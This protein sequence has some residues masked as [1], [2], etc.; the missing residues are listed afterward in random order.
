MTPSTT[1]STPDRRARSCRRRRG[2]RRNLEVDRRWRHLDAA[3]RQRE[4]QNRAIRRSRSIKNDPTGKTIYVADGRGSARHLVDDGGRRLA[5][6]GA[7][8]GGR[9][10]VDRRRRDV[11]AAR[12]AAN[13][14]AGARRP[15]SELRPPARHH[16][17][18]ARP[19]APRRRLR[20]R[21]T[22]RAS[23]A[24]TTTGRPGRRST[25]A[26]TCSNADRSEFDLATTPR[27]AT[28]ACT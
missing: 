23:C 21:R 19:D 24:R 17:R 2:R 27:T 14:L 10:E 11:H 12:S 22:D 13:G 8:R 9:L 4:L 1:R 3:R 15:P 7:P 5:V 18:R 16:R 6:P 26:L 25:S 28:R 20:D